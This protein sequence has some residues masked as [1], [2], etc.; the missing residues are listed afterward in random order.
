MGKK[1][2]LRLLICCSLFSSQTVFA[3]DI[4]GRSSTQF[5]SFNNE[6]L[7]DQRQIELAEYLRVSI[8]NLDKSGKFSI[9]GYGRGSQ[10]FTN[11]EGLNGR[12]YY[13]YGEYRDLFDKADIRI[14]RQFVNLAAGSAIIDGGQVD[15][16]N[17]GPVAFTVLG[18]RDVQFGLN[19]EIG[20]ATNTVLGM[21]AYLTGFKTTDAEISWFR[22]WDQGDVARDILGASAKQYLFSNLKAY[23]N[24]RYDLTAE[25]FNEVQGGLKFY[26]LSNLIF[27]GEYYTSY[28]TFDTTSF[29]SAFA[30][31]RYQEAVFRADYAFNDMISINGGY[32]RAFYGEGATANTYSAGI[33]LRPV[34][35]LKL[36]VEY[37]NRNGYYGSFNGA[38]VD[39]TYDVNKSAQVAGG[40]TYDVYQRDSLTGDEIARR[41]WLA[42]R[43]KIAGN[44]A[45]SGR[46][47]N[48][49][50]AR[51]TRN[52]SGRVTFDYDF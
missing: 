36:N 18:G 4:H 35:P 44:M 3:A 10:D 14:G 5:L 11:G 52:V 13:L 46:V 47:Q 43:Y 49:V 12:L 25:A 28:A 26:P 33:S 1:G 16:K 20:D 42:G 31:D 39:A 45:L 22:K 37:D 30:V 34:E 48:D 24:L 27:T 29:Y 21:G 23:G 2:L 50:N 32:K 7:A 6:L 15:L 51:Y 17:I 19:G 9:Y 41:Y 8:T 38:M 40:F